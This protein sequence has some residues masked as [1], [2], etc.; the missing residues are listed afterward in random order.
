MTVGAKHHPIL[1]A[2]AKGDIKLQRQ[3]LRQADESLIR[4]ISQIAANLITGNIQLNKSQKARLQKH[5]FI[6][7]E[8]RHRGTSLQQK[9]KLLLKQKGGFLPFIIPLVSTAL[10]G[11]ANAI[12]RK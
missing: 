12:F 1:I 10:G 9:R 7:R 6:L 8:L 11:L 4:L 3:I 2:L 5:K